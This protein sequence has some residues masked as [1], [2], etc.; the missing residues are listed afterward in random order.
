MTRRAKILV[1]GRVQG[2]F[3]R[4]SM[5]VEASRLGISGWVRNLDD[6][7]VEAVVEGDG[8]KVDALLAWARR[9]PAGSRVDSLELSELEPAECRYCQLLEEAGGAELSGPRGRPEFEVRY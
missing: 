3:Y 4:Q 9:G 5:K 1:S 6:G 8:G 2:V 7:R